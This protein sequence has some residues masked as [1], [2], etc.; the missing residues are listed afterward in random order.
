VSEP[1]T[2]PIQITT[3]VKFFQKTE[4]ISVLKCKHEKYTERVVIITFM[5]IS[6]NVPIFQ[7]LS[8]NNVQISCKK[9]KMDQMVSRFTTVVVVRLLV[10]QWP[11]IVKRMF[12]QEKLKQFQK[13]VVGGWVE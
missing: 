10:I 2:L 12:Y 7:N 5:L 6:R 8:D 13:T 9:K 3:T 11:A 4:L 1:D